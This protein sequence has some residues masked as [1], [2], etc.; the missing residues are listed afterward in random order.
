MNE[1]MKIYLEMEGRTRQEKR[2]IIQRMDSLLLGYGVK[3]S[4]MSNLY[5]PVVDRE[6]DDVFYTAKKMLAECEWLKG[7]FSHVVILDRTDVCLLSE[8]DVR[9]MASPMGERYHYYEKYYFLTGKL[10]HAILVDENRRLRKGYVSYLLSLKYGVKAEI[11]E[12]F[13]AQ[14]CRKIVIGRHVVRAGERYVYCGAKRYAWIYELEEPVVPG[15]I[16][17]VEMPEGHSCMC[18]EAVDY[19]TGIKFCAEQKNAREHVQSCICLAEEGSAT[20]EKDE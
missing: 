14:P 19:L 18:V 6:R 8:I 3:Y 4:G 1:M 11:K 13:S 10:P 9:H 7:I 2:R 5:L 12:V 17:I 15:D 20:E 16:L